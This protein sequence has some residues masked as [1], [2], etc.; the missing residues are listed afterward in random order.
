MATITAHG[1]TYPTVTAAKDRVAALQRDNRLYGA[2]D[3]RVTE[4][5][6]IEAA[7]A[8]RAAKREQDG[9][10]AA[11][12]TDGNEWRVVREEYGM[13]CDHPACAVMHR[14]LSTEPFSDGKAHDVWVYH[15]GREYT[16]RMTRWHETKR[17]DWIILRNGARVGSAHNTKREALAEASTRPTI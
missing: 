4:I 7:I 12:D 2:S 8:E 13:P 14:H 5:N 3:G 11:R 6:A 1:T 16:V 17:V 9:Y 15:N 10:L